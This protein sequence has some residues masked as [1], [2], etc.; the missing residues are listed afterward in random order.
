[1][2]PQPPLVSIMESGE[3]KVQSVCSPFGALT[4]PPLLLP[5]PSFLSPAIPQQYMPL[6]AALPDSR[7]A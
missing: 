5:S 3:G 6:P 7:G 1:M 4:L 2:K